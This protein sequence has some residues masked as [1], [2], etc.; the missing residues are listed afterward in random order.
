[1]PGK[2]AFHRFVTDQPQR[3][4]QRQEPRDRR[5]IVISVLCPEFIGAKDIQTPMRLGPWMLFDLFPS[6]IRKG[7]Q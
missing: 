6:R 4:M 5:R 3:F 7:N 2:T 1:M